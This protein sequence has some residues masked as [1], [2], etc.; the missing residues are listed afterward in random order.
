[1]REILASTFLSPVGGLILA[2]AEGR[3]CMCDWGNSHRHAL[4]LR[5]LSLSLRAE[6]KPGAS[7]LLDDATSQLTEYFNGRRQAFSLPLLAVGTPFQQCVWQALVQIPYG[8]T[9]SYS[10]LA[11]AMGMPRACRAVASAVA[12]NPISIFIPCHR[13]V[14]AA[15]MGGYAGGAS[16]KRFLLDLEEFLTPYFYS[17]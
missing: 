13:V 1:M 16:A 17:F 7:P 10:A 5:R 11:D 2:D 12:A 4:N 15:G 9:M 6:I 8:A 3:L 14:A